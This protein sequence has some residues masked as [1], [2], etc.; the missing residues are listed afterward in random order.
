MFV[1]SDLPSVEKSTQPKRRKIDN[2]NS[3]KSKEIEQRCEN[4]M[5]TTVQSVDVKSTPMNNPNIDI[6]D[7]N[8]PPLHDRNSSNE[9]FNKNIQA[10]IETEH[11]CYKDKII[12]EVCIFIIQFIATAYQ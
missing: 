3:A 11:A 1:V 7:V 9:Q 6:K 8:A 12:A 4:S 2:E 5:N 10:K